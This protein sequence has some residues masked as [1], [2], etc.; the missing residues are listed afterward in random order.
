MEY[1]PPD[2]K[3][4]NIDINCDIGEGQG[5]EAQLLPLISS[6][7]I[8]CGGHAG[9]VDSM[10]NCITLAQ[11]MG[12]KIGAHPSYPDRKNFGRSS[13]NISAERLVHSIRD[14]LSDF[15]I[16]LNQ[17]QAAL[18]HIKPHGALYNDM[19]KSR[20]LAE[21]FI[22][23]VEPFMVGVKLYAPYDSALAL[24][25]DQHKMEVS[26]EAFADRN[27]N[28]DLSLV[29]RSKPDAIITRP[30]A[31]LEHM[32]RMVRRGEVKTLQG[33]IMPIKASTY[34]IH[35]DTASAL[36][37]LTYLVEEL[38]GQRISIEK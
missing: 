24:V 34:C 2:V 25:A 20:V 11:Q 33:D 23:A 1:L 7:S 36:Q 9:D 35:G 17:Q 38:P 3:Q 5:N 21:T 27:Y 12:V 37:I 14:Q 29:S 30:Q 15:I 31:V 22:T 10:T 28:N 4:I 8:A 18:H 13:I 6:C 19:L 16:I 26:Y 32:V